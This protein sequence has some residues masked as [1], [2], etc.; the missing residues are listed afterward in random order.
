MSPQE[1]IAHMPWGMPA[2]YV[3][4]YD[5]GTVKVGRSANV[6]MRLTSL[7]TKV[8]S[9][10]RGIRE[11]SVYHADDHAT[12]SLET[13]VLRSIGRRATSLP[14]TREWFVGSYVDI[15]TEA[16]RIWSV[17]DAGGTLMAMNMRTDVRSG[18][19][20]RVPKIIRPDI[21]AVHKRKP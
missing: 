16:E 13:V 9:G 14:K 4:G 12:K 3:I 15:T 8:G 21:D 1:Q 2:L 11:F 19:Y 18:H 7:I 5:D 17:T 6:A 10:G 20:C